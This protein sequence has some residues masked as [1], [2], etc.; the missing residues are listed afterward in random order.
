MFILLVVFFFF[1]FFE[2]GS[3]VVFPD[4]G[5]DGQGEAGQR[6]QQVEDDGEVGARIGGRDP[7]EQEVEPDAEEV[8]HLRTGMD[9]VSE[10]GSHQ[11]QVAV[12]GAREKSYQE[13][14]VKS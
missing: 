13:K 8:H 4:E 11:R 9:K 5:E 7:G 2:S 3:A 6:H 10:L 14:F 12:A 1:V